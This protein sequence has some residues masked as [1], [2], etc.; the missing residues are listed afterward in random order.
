[1]ARAVA[2][3]A[4]RSRPAL[5]CAYYSYW[6][7]VPAGEEI[8]GYFPGAAGQVESSASD[9]GYQGAPGPGGGLFAAEDHGEVEESRSAGATG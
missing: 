4:Y 3:P 2:A 6:S 1:M 9:A 5:T 8:E 7:D